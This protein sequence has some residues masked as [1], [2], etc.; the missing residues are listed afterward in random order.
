MKSCGENEKRIPFVAQCKTR[1]DIFSK[2]RYR[3]DFLKIVKLYGIHAM[4]R[5]KFYEKEFSMVLHECFKTWR[6][7]LMRNGFTSLVCGH[8]KKDVTE[9]I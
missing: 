6:Y 8:W 3:A 2:I 9:L 1:R 5:I 4:Q 7:C